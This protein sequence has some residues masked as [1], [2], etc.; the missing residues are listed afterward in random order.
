MKKSNITVTKNFI[1]FS[2][3]LYIPLFVPIPPRRASNVYEEPLAL[4]EKTSS[5]ANFGIPFLF[6]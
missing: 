5:A 6:L 3:L 1:I 4:R 2:K